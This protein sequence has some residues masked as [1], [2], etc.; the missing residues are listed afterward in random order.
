[1]RRSTSLALLFWFLMGLSLALEDVFNASWARTTAFAFSSTV[2]LT[3]LVLAWVLSHAKENEIQTPRSLNIAVV[4][5]GFI[6]V[7]YYRFRY[8]GLK[9]GFIFLGWVLLS[10]AGVIMVLAGLDYLVNGVS[11]F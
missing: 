4:A 8:F 5:V 11:P 10:L 9:D 3:L 1:M 6:A 7:P 2:L